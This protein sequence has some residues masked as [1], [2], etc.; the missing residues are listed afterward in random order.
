MKDWN[1]VLTSHMGEEHRLL[2]EVADYGEFHR[3]G[4][5]EVLIGK[6]PDPAE[7][8]E[9]LKHSW[10]T[11]PFLSGI[12]ST[13]TPVDRL[14]SFSTEELMDRLR[15]ESLA[16]LPR[17]EGKAFY[18]RVKRRGH[19]GEISSQEVEQALD[20]FLLDE[21][22]ARGREGRIDFHN[23]DAILFV[24]IIHNQCGLTVITPEMK[25][26]YPFIKVK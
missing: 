22:A 9:I 21:L 16:F 23:P 13:A 26:R 18:V 10:E 2:Q 19:K 20:R 8:M 3:S 12:L 6:V 15:Q 7:F 5:R 1:V 4:F 11:Q 14:F 17:L 25:Q 24:E